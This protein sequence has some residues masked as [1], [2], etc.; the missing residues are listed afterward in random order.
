MKPVVSAISDCMKFSYF[1]P[2]LTVLVHIS[3]SISAENVTTDI[4]QHHKKQIIIHEIA[5]K[6]V[7]LR[8]VQRGFR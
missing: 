5:S 6:I 8:K 4:W 7:Q 3:L 2:S 1:S